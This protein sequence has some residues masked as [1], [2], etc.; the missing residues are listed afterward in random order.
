MDD[1]KIFK[2]AKNLFNFLKTDPSSVLFAEETLDRKLLNK[3]KKSKY[4]TDKLLFKLANL[5]D[6]KLILN[7][8]K[9]PTRVDYAEKRE[10]DRSTLYSLDGPFQLLHSDVR[11]LEFY[12]KNATFPQYVLVIVDLFS[13][14]VYTYSMKS[15]K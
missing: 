9:A 14:K 12:R 11:N 3:L 7:E 1:K 5:S 15:R 8:D 10:I 13:S 6:S 4:E 2:N